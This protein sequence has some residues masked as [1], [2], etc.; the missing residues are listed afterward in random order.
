MEEINKESGDDLTNTM[1]Q[2]LE[3]Y[4]DYTFSEKPLN[5]VDALILS[6]LAYLKYDGIVPGVHER[7]KSVSIS[8][9]KENADFDRL[10]ADERFRV[11]NEAL[12]ESAWKSQRYRKMCLNY[13]I[14][15]T[16]LEWETQFA[17]V[18]FILEDGT[19]FVAYR[20]TDETIVG[21]KEDLNMGFMAPVPSQ[22]YGSKYLNMISDRIRNHFYL[23]GHSKGGNVAVYAAMKAIKDVRDKIITIYNLD[24]PGFRPELL[25]KYDYEEIKDRIVK[26]VP[27]S[28]LVGMIFGN[29]NNYKVIESDEFGLLQHDPYSWLVEDDHFLYVKGVYT[30]RKFW[31]ETLNEW[32]FS[33]EEKDIEHFVDTLYQIIC[34]SQADDLIEFAANWKESVASML[35]A[36]KDTDDETKDHMKKVTKSLFEMLMERMKRNLNPREILSKE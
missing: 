33:L 29:E 21:W 8:Y 23:G 13:Y 28:S 31:D 4:G 25:E 22:D 35:A 24:G 15:I 5:E 1:L 11:E 3:E 6:Q 30:L 17:A 27:H 12:F 9:I 36:Y 20:G 18:T 10:F 26:I 32:L 7:R 16:E 14:S 2:Y 34:A 19:I